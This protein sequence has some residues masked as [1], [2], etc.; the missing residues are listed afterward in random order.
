MHGY[1]EIT[2]KGCTRL[3]NLTNTVGTVVVCGTGEI[4]ERVTF[5][6]LGKLLNHT[7]TGEPFT[8]SYHS[9]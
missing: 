8:E 1:S 7:P 2:L 5:C 4:D 9:Y 6:L 3:Y